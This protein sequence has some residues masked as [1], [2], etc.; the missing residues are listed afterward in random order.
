MNNF[1]KGRKVVIA[2]MHRKEMVISPIVERLGMIPEVAFELNTDKF[3]TFSGEIERI[4]DPIETLRRKCFAALEVYDS[5]I[6]I[7]SEGSF[8]PHPLYHFIP[9]DDELI[10]L[11]DRKHNLEVIARE[12]STET[13]FAQRAVETEEELLLFAQNSGF[14]EHGLILRTDRN[15]IQKGIMNKDILVE[16]FRQY[17]NSGVR[18]ITVETDMRALF[19]PTRMKVIAAAVEKLFTALRSECPDCQMPGFT[20]KRTVKGLPCAQCGAPTDSTKYG[21][22][23]CDTCGCEQQE[24][25]RELEDPMYCLFCN[26]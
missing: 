11:V 22:K 20:V 24:S 16:S 13:N 3:G 23:V 8:G 14:P 18:A 1:F 21:I 26:P 10:M 4:G 2:S 6:V 17:R 19:N 12:L 25:I 9:C 7:A 5:D 15:D